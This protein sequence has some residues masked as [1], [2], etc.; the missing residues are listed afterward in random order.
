LGFAEQGAA[1]SLPQDCGTGAKAG[2]SS[3]P[4]ACATGGFGTGTKP[5][6]T[7]VLLDADGDLR[8]AQRQRW[9]RPAAGKSFAR[10]D[11][12]TAA[13]ILLGRIAILTGDD[14]LH[15]QAWDAAART[16][17]G[18]VLGIT[19]WADEPGGRRAD[20]AAIRRQ[21]ADHAGRFALACA[22]ADVT[23]ADGACTVTCP[24]VSL[25]VDANGQIVTAAEPAKPAIL[26]W[27]FD[28]PRDLPPRSEA[29]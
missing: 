22:V 20:A 23:T 3:R 1:K 5:Y 24:G 25:V 9:F 26:W 6:V 14:L 10:G 8:L 11:G 7:G 29:E 12:V 27:D 17:A 15:S 16:G 13:D 18:M 19:C 2:V 28:L 21:L 4:E